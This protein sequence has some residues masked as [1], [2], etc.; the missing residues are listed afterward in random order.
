MSEPTPV[1]GLRDAEIERLRARIHEAVDE[2]QRRYAPEVKELARLRDVRQA[3]RRH[4]DEHA[5]KP[6]TYISEIQRAYIADLTEQRDATRVALDRVRAL[7]PTPR[8]SGPL[9]CNDNHEISHA[10]AL[11]LSAALDGPG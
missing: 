7:L 1:T 4:Y 11:A 9:R 2:C 8:D 5:D 10:A 3:A 6:W